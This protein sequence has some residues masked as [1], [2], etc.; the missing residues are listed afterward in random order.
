MKFEDWRLQLQ[1]LTERYQCDGLVEYIIEACRNRRAFLFFAPDGWVVLEPRAIPDRHIFVLA[2][3]CESQ[4]AIARYEQDI[5]ALAE[6]LKTGVVRFEAARPG[7]KKV[8]P[9]RGWLLLD[10]GKTWERDNG[11][12]GQ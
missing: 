7:Y 8:M 5:F 1:Q 2:A 9:Q 4:G 11:W 3:Y 10:D 12:K 6:R